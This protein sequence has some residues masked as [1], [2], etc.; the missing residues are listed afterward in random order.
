MSSNYGG[1]V[2]KISLDGPLLQAEQSVGLSKSE[3]RDIFKPQNSPSVS[4][5]LA[6][7]LCLP[8]QCFA[9]TFYLA[10]IH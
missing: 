9:R 3:L 10:K 1:Y 5:Q 8:K 2:I 7:P 6:S 4:S